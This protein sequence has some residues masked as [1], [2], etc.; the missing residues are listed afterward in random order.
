MDLLVKKGEGLRAGPGVDHSEKELNCSAGSKQRIL[1][2]QWWRCED[3]GRRSEENGKC[4]GREGI[5]EWGK[6]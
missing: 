4:L 1:A 2:F 5:Q 6:E 3:V